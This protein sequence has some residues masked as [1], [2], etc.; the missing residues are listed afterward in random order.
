MISAPWGL[1]MIGVVLL[2]SVGLT[3]AFDIG[4][5]RQHGPSSLLP[6]V[7]ERP[8]SAARLRALTDGESE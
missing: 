5:A 8:L 1:A 3:R 6:R 7:G 4:G 2:A